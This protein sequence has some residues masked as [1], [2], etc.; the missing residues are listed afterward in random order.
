MRPKK[1]AKAEKN[2]LSQVDAMKTHIFALSFLLLFIF[3]LTS[4]AQDT[5]NEHPT[6]VRADWAA[7]SVIVGGSAAMSLTLLLLESEISPSQCKWCRQNSFDNAVTDA[8][9]WPNPKYAATTSDIIAFGVIPALSLGGIALSSSL[10]G[11]Y[12]ELGHDT[13]IMAQVILLN[14]MI[15]QFTKLVV[16]RERP[17]V[18]RGNIGGY[19]NENDKNLSFYSGHSSFVF[20]TVVGAATLAHYQGYDAEPYIWAIGIPLATLVAYL[21]VAAQKHYL[22]DVLVGAGIGSLIGF[23]IPYL[24]RENA[25][26]Q[27]ST[28]HLWGSANEKGF[29]LTYGS[30]F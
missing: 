17:Y 10:S 14:T 24:H 19:N 16:G 9:T 26:S 8:L 3:P 1:Q 23:L 22:S 6:R 12:Q 13:M 25:K 11:R 7:D 28:P 27:K 5:T 30:Q 21:R 18:S 29:F 4:L 2:S 15:N 20:A